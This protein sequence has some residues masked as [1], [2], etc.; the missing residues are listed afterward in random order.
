MATNHGDG[1]GL[2]MLAMDT[3]FEKG[4][5]QTSQ[6][7]QSTST[8]TNDRAYQR[9]DLLDVEIE[10]TSSLDSVRQLFSHTTIKKL[11]VWSAKWRPS[12][13]VHPSSGLKQQIDLLDS[14]NCDNNLQTFADHPT[15]NC[16]N[17]QP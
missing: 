3:K 17:I 10:K 13:K 6:K 8:S 9:D 12:G 5:R 16:E 7:L 14:A 2:K 15:E 1:S 4:D 11:V